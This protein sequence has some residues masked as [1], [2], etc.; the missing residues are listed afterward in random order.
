MKGATFA[1]GVLQLHL[2]FASAVSA[3]WNRGAAERALYYAVYVLE[4]IHFNQDAYDGWK[5]APGCVGTRKGI[6]GQKGRCN[7]AEFCD[8]IWATTEKDERPPKDKIKWTKA[9]VGAKMPDV[10]VSV[11]MGAKY[12]DGSFML[13]HDTT[14]KQ[15]GYTGN[16]DVSGRVWPGEA[17]VTDYWQ[18][19]EKFGPRAAV[20]KKDFDE[21]VKSG[22]IVTDPSNSKYKAHKAVIDK[23]NDFY[24]AATNAAEIVIDW[25]V[26][27]KWRHLETMGDW[28]NSLGVDGVWEEKASAHSMVGNWNEINK[29]KTLDQMVDKLGITREEATNK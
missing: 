12:T 10:I 14:P 16:I 28:K 7:L 18:S 29:E 6:W 5:I 13:R 3:Y 1:A 27:D 2:L 15:Y 21:A 23:F 19:L 8:W 20:L 22:A 25:R 26:Q 24:T 17:G 11:I 9:M 4:D